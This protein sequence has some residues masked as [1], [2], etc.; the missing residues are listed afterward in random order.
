MSCH[1]CFLELTKFLQQD[2]EI[3]SER[4]YTG[5]MELQLIFKNHCGWVQNIRGKEKIFIN[6]DVEV[7]GARSPWME[8]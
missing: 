7:E 6:E 2:Y 3:I 5:F 4:K 8:N 1:M